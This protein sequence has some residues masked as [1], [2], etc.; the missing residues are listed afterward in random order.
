MNDRPKF[1][2]INN[3][4]KDLRGH[5]F[6]NALSI[7]EAA[8]DMGWRPILAGHAT[9]KNT[10]I[11]NWLEFYPIFRVD[12]LMDAPPYVT[13]DDE[14]HINFKKYEETSIENVINESSSFE[15]YIRSRFYINPELSEKVN[16]SNQNTNIKKRPYIFQ[17]LLK[18]M[19]RVNKKII[20][21]F[22]NFKERKTRISEKILPLEREL[23]NKHVF[24]L[25]LSKLL[26]LTGA[27]GGD[28][29][30]LPTA[31]GRELMAITELLNTGI[32]GINFGLEFR[33]SF[34]YDASLNS[35]A[36]EYLKDHC[37]YFTETK[38]NGLRPEIK[39]FADTNELLME[40]QN[41]SGLSF[42]LLPIPIRKKNISKIKQSKKKNT[43]INL[44]F[45]GDPR[46]EKG[47]H[48]LPYLVDYLAKE[49]FE[50]GKVVLHVQA[51]IEKPYEPRCSSVLRIL[52]SYPENWIKLHALT[53][54]LI[55]E[56]YYIL[57]NQANIMLCP[58]DNK[59][60]KYRSSGTLAEA[61]AAGIPTLVPSKTWLASEQPEGLNISF[62]DL[63]S[64]LT[65]SKNLIDNLE[66]Y[67]AIATL[68]KEKYLVK[69]NAKKLIEKITFG[70]LE[71][72]SSK[73]LTA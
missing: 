27:K 41:F 12:H 61:I 67:Q 44:M 14:I 72:T 65:K 31:H 50:T 63:E 39:L 56:D 60:Y 58:Y 46:E 19:N 22:K 49:Y 2:I 21:I 6:E 47:F 59:K 70:G 34:E 45:I 16:Y 57:L 26:A 4:M 48:W 40:H 69:H 36:N 28:Y 32:K 10:I 24:Y 1:Y 38:K 9:C 68:S 71:T 15:D 25:D 11:P 52:K 64:F 13:G 62:D 42:E 29:V 18:T 5:Y 3:G 17:V 7:A 51:S 66:H 33:Y 73:R 8:V 30:F 20:S 35:K 55:S 53:E 54:P 43:P 23:F 37:Y